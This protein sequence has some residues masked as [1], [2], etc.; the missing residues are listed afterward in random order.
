MASAARGRGT[1]ARC[2]WMGAWCGR[3]RI[4][5]QHLGL[6]RGEGLVTVDPGMDGFD[7]VAHNHIVH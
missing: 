3:R 7:V 5:I 4:S 1:V 6:D 2:D